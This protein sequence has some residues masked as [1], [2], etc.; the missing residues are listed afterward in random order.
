M[1]INKNLL[2]SDGYQDNWSQHYIFTP[3]NS[4]LHPISLSR[5]RNASMNAITRR[6]IYIGRDASI[7]II[8]W[9]LIY[10]YLCNEVKY[11][12]LNPLFIIVLVIGNDCTG[13]VKWRIKRL[14]VKTGL[15]RIFLFLIFLQ[16]L[17]CKI[18]TFI[19]FRFF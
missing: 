2:S 7:D 12:F 8:T 3:K 19:L 17:F 11:F 16:I 18:L 10:I 6:L 9:R 4:C 14:P 13:T 5:W 1:T 15:Y